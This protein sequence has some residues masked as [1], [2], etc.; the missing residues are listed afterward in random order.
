VITP[1]VIE[2]QALSALA[3]H[4]AEHLAKLERDLGLPARTI[5]PFRTVDLLAGD[6]VR[7]RE[8]NP[9]AVL[10]GIFG[11]S[12]RPEPDKNGDLTFVWQLAA[13][14]VT[15]GQDRRDTI[16]RRG[17]YAMVVAQC[18]V[19]RLP[20]QAAPVDSVSLGDVEFTNG[21]TG[22]SRP[23][24]VGEAQLF[25]DV[26]VRGTLGPRDLPPI[27]TP[28]PPGSPGGPPSEPYD[29]PVPWPQVATAKT[30]T[31]KEPIE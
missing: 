16:K 15:V 2:D 8:D 25:F 30:T 9:P 19:W 4:H 20:R 12:G 21:R 27:D 1:D 24:T 3:D 6:G 18:M 10:L 31:D 22:D 17:W 26:R 13:Q 28:L 7:L 29:P 11:T 14:V 5:E 23:R